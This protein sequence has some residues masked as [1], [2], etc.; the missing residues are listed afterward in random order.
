M[1]S[2]KIFIEKIYGIIFKRPLQNITYQN[3]DFVLQF[4]KFQSS[5]FHILD[6]K[7]FMG[8]L[9]FEENIYRISFNHVQQ[10]F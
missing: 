1:F 6:T 5:D 7:E 10:F 9:R 2:E 4:L 3:F 8:T